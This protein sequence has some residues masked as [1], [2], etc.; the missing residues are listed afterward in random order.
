MCELLAISSNTPVN[1]SFTWRGFIKRGLRNPDGWGIAFYKD[2]TAL[3]YKEPKPAPESPLAHFLRN[4]IKS[5]LIISHV[6]WATK[7]RAKYSNTHPFKREVYGREWVFAHNGDVSCIVN[8]P[9]FKLEHYFPVGETDSEYAFCYMLDQI[10]EL[11]R[12]RDYSILRLSKRIL[13]IAMKI[14]SHG[15]FNFLLSNGNELYAYMN[16]RQT[17]YYLLRHPPHRAYARLI[18]EDYE[19]NL[20]EI[21]GDNEYVVLIAT[22]P[23]TNEQWR[24]FPANELLVFRDGNLLLKASLRKLEIPLTTPEKNVLKIVRK[25]KHSIELTKIAERLGIDKEEARETVK[26]LVHKKLLK[27]DRRGPKDLERTNIRLYTS[28][29]I[30]EILDKVVLQK[31]TCG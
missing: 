23:I 25:S 13:Q 12:N 17:L 31:T 2:D 22:K 7:G 24:P 4:I 3:I 8:N 9:D 11:T 14:G 15:K 1:I 5:R 28:K 10:R 30:R 27:I 16:R 26:A 6:R 19:V 21:K 18:D 29:H 20:S